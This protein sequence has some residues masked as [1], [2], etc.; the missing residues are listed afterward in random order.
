MISPARLAAYRVLR[1]VE[2][3]RADLPGALARERPALEDDRD[4]ALAADIAAG[5]LRWRAALDHVIAHY[6]R[7]PLTRL[8]DEVIDI[9]R[10]S[11]YQLLHHD[12]VP[13]SAVVDDAVSLTGKV[14]KRSA[15]GFVNAVL[16]TTARHRHHVPLPPAPPFEHAPATPEEE[17]ALLDYF[18]ISL[19]HPRWL[20]T[21]WL[22]RYGAEAVDRWLRFDNE[23]APLTLR[24]N[25][26]RLDRDELA[27]LLGDHG[28]R[29]TP[30]VY[31]PDGLVVVE[32]SPFRTPLASAGL[33][34][35][36]DEA[37]QLVALMTAARRGERVLDACAAPGGKTTAMVGAMGDCGLV[38]AADRRHRRL[39]LLRDA[40]MSSGAR[41]VHIVQ[42]D[43]L[44]PLPFGDAFDCVLVDAPCS[45]LGTI[46][47][48]PEIRWR[49]SEEDLPS[50]ADRQ[51][52]MLT[53]AARVVRTGGRLVYATCS[54]EPEENE[55]VVERFLLAH[56]DFEPL[57]ARDAGVSP[58]LTPVTDEAGHLR[59]WPH[60]HGLEAFFAAILR[61]RPRAATAPMLVKAQH[62]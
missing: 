31:A 28:V 4:R 37:S 47:R 16:R 38:V 22:R 45:G 61:R 62:L 8:D 19:S 26:A 18:S 54:S 3:G 27:R 7:R 6:A 43:L 42:L 60:L 2:T 35:P 44:H 24:A 48:V 57:P 9:L 1:A 15:G 13:A 12:R 52:T 59:T 56:P 14:G 33:F 41:S 50:L 49:R 58:A 17:R 20:V 40:V 36:Q 23:P 30:T 10:L 32:G 5:T 11:A 55:Q 46:R 53:Q 29:T 25:R 34:S 51:V 39:R 21:R